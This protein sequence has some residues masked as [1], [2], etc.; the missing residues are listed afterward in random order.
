M[1]RRLV[2]TYDASHVLLV[3]GL[4][5]VAW[6]CSDSANGGQEGEGEGTAEGEG[7]GREGEGEASDLYIVE[8]YR[9]EAG[10]NPERSTNRERFG[11]DPFGGSWKGFRCVRDPQGE[12]PSQGIEWISIMGGSFFMGS[13]SAPETSPV[14]EVTVQDF[15]MMKTEVTMVMYQTC[16]DQGICTEPIRALPGIGCGWYDRANKP[17]NPIDCVSK[18]QARQFCGFVGGRLPSESQWEFAARSGGLN[19]NYPWGNEPPSCDLVVMTNQGVIGCGTGKIWP[20]CSKLEGNSIQ[21]ICDLIGNAVEMVDDCWHDS[22]L[23]AP[24]DGSPWLDNC[25]LDL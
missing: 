22:Y 12:T 4:A 13:I 20:V 1:S 16:I 9:G 8:T 3:M 17:D 24:I 7:E 25:I 5:A 14:H 23:G 2:S 21:G 19:I 10:G 11:L 6:A 18:E 15:S